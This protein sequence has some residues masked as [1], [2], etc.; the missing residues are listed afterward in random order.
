MDA[1]LPRVDVDPAEPLMRADG[2]A[3]AFNGHTA[4]ADVSFSVRAGE[5]VAVLGPSGAGKTTLFRCLAGLAPPDAGSVR[6][7][8]QDIARAA[9][10]DRWRLARDVAVVFQQ[11]NLVGRLTALD[12]VLA[13]R[14]G[15]V[16][17]W[18]G[19]SHRFDRADRLLALECLDRVG[20]LAKAGQ[21]ADTLSGGQQQRVAIAR[22]LAQRPRLIVADEPVASLDPA[23]AAGV[24]DLLRD[25]ARDAQGNDGGVGVV[26]SLHQVDLARAAADRIIGLA[27][28]RVMAD[29]PAS[30]FDAAAAAR[31]YGN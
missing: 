14:L 24:L 2:L 29:L 19:W 1:P 15:H 12:N 17:A 11:F 6:V 18:R 8:G 9:G 30:L 13:G 27:G 10:R 7:G 21:R 16:P 28:G 23:T 25:I 31:L 22:A 5:V 3:K 20:L 26:C 4:L